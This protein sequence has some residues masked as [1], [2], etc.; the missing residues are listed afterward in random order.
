MFNRLS[1]SS[2]FIVLTRRFEMDIREERDFNVAEDVV[3]ID[4]PAGDVDA[5]NPE[6]GWGQEARRRFADRDWEA[7][8]AELRIE[9]EK[10]QKAGSRT[11]EDVRYAVRRGWD[12]AKEGI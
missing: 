1:A 11:W 10:A 2:L 3:D 8:E 6:Y 4:A 5:N 7:A 12:S 9:W